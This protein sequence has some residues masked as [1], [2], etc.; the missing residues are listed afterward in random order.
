MFSKRPERR[1]AWYRAFILLHAVPLLVH[2]LK[3]YNQN[4][5]LCHYA[6][7]IIFLFL[8]LLLFNKVIYDFSNL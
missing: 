8:F 6:C 5:I 2:E 3:I 1:T 7:E 4:K